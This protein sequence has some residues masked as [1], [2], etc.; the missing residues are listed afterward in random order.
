MH[1]VF[2]KIKELSDS[3]ELVGFILLTKNGDIAIQIGSVGEEFGECIFF[4]NR[5]KRT[6]SHTDC[7]LE[8]YQIIP[9]KDLSVTLPVNFAISEVRFAED[10][11]KLK[12]AQIFY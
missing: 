12:N 6:I 11:Q 4:N 10:C 7:K 2:Q 3:S 1:P 8:K 9:T 5:Y